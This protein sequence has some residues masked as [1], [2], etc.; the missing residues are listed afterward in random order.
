[1]IQS[2]IN[3]FQNTSWENIGL[4]LLLLYSRIV[5]N[6]AIYYREACSKNAWLKLMHIHCEH[7]SNWAKRMMVR[8]K[9][10]PDSASWG[11][12]FQ[13]YTDEKGFAADEHS[14]ELLDDIKN[15]N[16]FRT[17]MNNSNIRTENMYDTCVIVKTPNSVM[18]RRIGDGLSLPKIGDELEKS[19]V[20][21]VSVE[22]THPDLGEPIPI[23]LSKEYWQVGNEL[24]SAAF[25]LRYLEYQPENYSFDD[26]YKVVIMDGN[27]DIIEL[28][29]GEYIVLGL[30]KYEIMAKLK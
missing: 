3:Y 18:C 5:A 4:D 8:H 27:M 13:I 12:I 17:F 29:L 30:N 20:R 6:V 23:K 22:Y 10:D 24:F 21:F 19:N 9:L 1:M 16:L 28:H 26:K 2:W 14:Y 25:V 7:V 11:M 15:P